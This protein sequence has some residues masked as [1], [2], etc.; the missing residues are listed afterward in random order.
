MKTS[1]VI[2]NELYEKLDKT[3]NIIEN[4]YS[5]DIQLESHKQSGCFGCRGCGGTCSGNC[6]GSCSGS[7]RGDCT[8]S[9]SGCSGQRCTFQ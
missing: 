9:C 4:S 1:F 7:C 6:S 2:S 5:N 8:G 3:L